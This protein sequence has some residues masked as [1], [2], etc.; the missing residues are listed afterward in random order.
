MSI[1]RNGVTGQPETTLVDP[2]ALL[3]ETGS[4][5]SEERAAKAARIR[6]GLQQFAH[7]TASSER[8]LQEKWAELDAERRQ[9]QRD[10]K[11]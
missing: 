11:R 1:V 6:E 7:L 10:P 9:Y 2:K 5:Q 3:D 8:F 4:A